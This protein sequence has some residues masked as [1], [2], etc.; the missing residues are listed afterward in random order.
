MLENTIK[1]KKYWHELIVY[2]DLII[3]TTI[4]TWIKL[5][6]INTNWHKHPKQMFSISRSVCYFTFS[7]VFRFL[8]IWFGIPKDGSTVTSHGFHQQNIA[9]EGWTFAPFISI[10]SVRTPLFNLISWVYIY[11]I[12]SVQTFTK[13]WVQVLF[14]WNDLK[15]C[16]CC[17]FKRSSGDD[18]LLL[19]TTL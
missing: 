11:W 18:L 9:P 5:C 17:I 14:G 13:I 8:N 10:S 3:I 12:T 15:P 4:F 16:M 7:Y 6:T 2:L 1:L 19:L